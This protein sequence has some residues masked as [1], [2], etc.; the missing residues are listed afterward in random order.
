MLR[1]LGVDTLNQSKLQHEIEVPSIPRY[2]ELAKPGTI[3]KLVLLQPG[4]KVQ[5]VRVKNGAT[6][7]M[8]ETQEIRSRE[9]EVECKVLG[10]VLG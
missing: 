5:M 1:S 4:R 8:R 6:Q 2:G 9:P 10:K 3:Y 7:T